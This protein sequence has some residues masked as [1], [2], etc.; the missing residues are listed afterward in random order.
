MLHSTS[1]KAGS[2]SQKSVYEHIDIDLGSEIFDLP[3]PYKTV[4]AKIIATPDKK[5][6]P[7]APG[8]FWIESPMGQPIKRLC[9][10]EDGSLLEN[11]IHFVLKT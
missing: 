7:E 9:F 8:H 2:R 11:H 3:P 1:L 10:T 6:D 5:K 4:E